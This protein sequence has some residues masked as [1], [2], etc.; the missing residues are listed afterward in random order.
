MASEMVKKA[1]HDDMISNLPD[2]ILSLILSSLPIK[3]AV[4]TS[5][6][7]TRW[8]YLSA[9]LFNLDVDFR[10]FRRSPHIK[11]FTTF[12][13]KMLFFRSEG[14]IEQFRLYHICISEIDDSRV[15]GWIFAALWLGVK[16]INMVFAGK[17][18]NIPTLLTA[19]LFT[20][21]SLVRLKLDMPF[22]MTVPIHVRLPSLKTL[23]LRSVKFEDDD[24]IK[25]VFAGCPLLEDLSIFDCDLRNITCLKI[26]NPSLTSLT[27]VFID[28]LK[29]NSFSSLAFS[30]DIDLPSLVYFKY[31]GFT[32]INYS[33][34]HMP[35]LVRADVKI[36]GRICLT[37]EIDGL[38]ELFQRIDNVKSLH[39]SINAEAL[40][41][42]SHKSFAAFQNL[43]KLDIMDWR[44]AYRG[45][46][47]LQFFEFSPN[48]QTLVIYKVS[49]NEAW[50]P[51]EKVPSC[52]V[53]QL[54]EFKVLDFDDQSCLFILVTYILKNAAVLEKLTICTSKVLMPR[55]ELKI[56]KQLLSLPRCSNKCQV[57]AF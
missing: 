20:S 45:R 31:Q 33:A 25:R 13:D 3:N 40:P 39:L 18:I 14:R 53:H 37:R 28:N 43:L 44:N 24:S 29:V 22:L 7:S 2:S 17:Y 48:L 41:Y 55:E 9:A 38:V 56:I 16:E 36:H 23:E 12:M 27:L 32:K 19:L 15:F 49:S 21:K 34:L 47:I 54:K 42:L 57:T 46:G 10:L 8:R 1:K 52:L 5:I 6:L 30:I 50:L 35:S 11:S 4:S 26:S 51:M